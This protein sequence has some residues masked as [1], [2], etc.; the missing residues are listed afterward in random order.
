MELLKNF[1]SEHCFDNRGRRN[2]R[3][4]PGSFRRKNSKKMQTKDDLVLS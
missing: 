2:L 4:K 1:N 3:K